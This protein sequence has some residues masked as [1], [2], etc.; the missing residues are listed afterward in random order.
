MVPVHRLEVVVAETADQVVEAGLDLVAATS[1][2]TA[3]VV[4]AAVEAMVAA[5]VVMVAAA[6]VMV[7]VEVEATVAVHLVPGTDSISWLP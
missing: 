2:G 5:V 3:G 6:V 1:V 7:V 4:A